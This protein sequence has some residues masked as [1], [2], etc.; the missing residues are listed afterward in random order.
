MEQDGKQ[1][2]MEVMGRLDKTFKPKLNES[3]YTVTG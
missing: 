1:R 2:L 3:Q